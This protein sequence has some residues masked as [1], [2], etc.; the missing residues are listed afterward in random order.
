MA[1]KKIVKK[2]LTLEEQIAKGKEQI[3]QFEIDKIALTKAIDEARKILLNAEGNLLATEAKQKNA[4][5]DINCLEEQLANQQ[6]SPVELQKKN[7][8]RRIKNI[9]R[10]EDWLKAEDARDTSSKNMGSRI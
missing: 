7:D 4:E 5:S 9:K 2:E 10:H 1:T 3:A 8:L 6:L